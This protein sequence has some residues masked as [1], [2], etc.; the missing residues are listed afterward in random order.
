MHHLWW[1]VLTCV[2]TAALPNS[3]F[4]PPQIRLAIDHHQSPT[5]LRH[6][7][8]DGTPALAGV[9][10]KSAL[11]VADVQMGNPR[12]ALR[13]RVVIGTGDTQV[14][15][16]NAVQCQAANNTCPF[17][18]Y[19]PSKSSSYSPQAQTFSLNYVDGTGVQGQFFADDTELDGTLVKDFEMALITNGTSD[20]KFNPRGKGVPLS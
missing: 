19:D 18:R 7:R 11:L 16:E 1:S 3:A 8:R 5:A 14:I 15:A 10:V 20:S 17:E 12:Q 4:L 9:D 6:V 13:L 2:L